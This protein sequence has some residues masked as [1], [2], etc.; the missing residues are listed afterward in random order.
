ML[1]GPALAILGPLLGVALAP[2]CANGGDAS[3]IVLRSVAPTSAME[4]TFSASSTELTVSSGA[5][6]ATAG[7]G[8]LLPLQ[9]TTRITAATGMENQRL[10]FVTGALV[11]VSFPDATMFSADLLAQWKAEALTHF[12]AQG[13]VLINPN[14]G[15]SDTAFEVF[16]GELALAI[17]QAAPS[18]L[19]LNA[20]VTLKVIAGLGQSGTDLSSDPFEF[21]I[22]LLHGGLTPSKGPC[23]TLPSGFVPRK[24]S[25]CNVGQDGITDC[26]TDASMNLVCPAV[27]TAS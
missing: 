27:G 11:D 22:T 1:R 16:P 24:G 12:K 23:S 25:P 5:L 10:V 8:Y 13:A 15:L 3:I 26:C 18:F 14:G 4:C 17:V 21:P 2:G 6:D 7:T 9:L 20:V 19:T